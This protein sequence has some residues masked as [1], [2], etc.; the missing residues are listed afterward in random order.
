MVGQLVM[1]KLE[2]IRRKKK[3]SQVLFL[4]FDF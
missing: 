4:F 2:E 1:E 3:G